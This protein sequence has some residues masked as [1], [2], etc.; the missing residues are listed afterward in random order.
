MFWSPPKWPFHL[1]PFVGASTVD[2]SFRDAVL[3]YGRVRTV[4]CV[5]S[6]VPVI[7]L[8]SG[9][10]LTV[11]KCIRHKVLTPHLHYI[12]WSYLP[13]AYKGK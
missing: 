3:G 1:F 6:T 13:N 2:S 4:S 12:P 7:V 10:N 11:E 8:R 5:T 9:N